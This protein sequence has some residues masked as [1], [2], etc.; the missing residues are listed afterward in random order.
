VHSFPFFSDIFL[1][2]CD[3]EIS[4]KQ[5]EHVFRLISY[6]GISQS[7][8][9]PFI[10]APIQK[11]DN[12]ETINRKIDFTT[13][14]LDCFAVYRLLL[15]L[16]I[17][18]S[19]IRNAIYI[20]IKEIR[21]IEFE[22]LIQILKPEI[23]EYKTNFLHDIDYLP[24][25]ASYAKY[26]FS[27]LLKH[28]VPDLDFENIFFQRRKDA[29][30]LYQF[31][32]FNDVEKEVHKI[33]TGLKNIFIESLCSYCIAPIDIITQAEKLPLTRRIPF[34]IKKNILFDVPEIND[35]QSNELKDFFLNRNKTLKEL[36]I[37][38]W[39]L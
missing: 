16:P 11:I 35:F 28:H 24:F 21:N 6:K 8:S 20:K 26:I 5:P 1:K 23:N 2:L 29:Y 7:L 32:T 38:H 4:D 17:T 34:L 9:Y 30:L 22:E 37:N 18:H 3:F 14:F 10:L 33:P 39:K 25:N 36:I 19:S 31:L 13:R 12:Q 27:R 15:N